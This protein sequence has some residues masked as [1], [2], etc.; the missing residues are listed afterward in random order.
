MGLKKHSIFSSKHNDFSIY[1]IITL[2]L[3]VLYII[4]LGKF[5]YDSFVELDSIYS[6]IKSKR[7]DE[8]Q[9]IAEIVRLKKLM[10]EKIDMIDLETDSSIQK[11]VTS[12]K[13]FNNIWYIPK[14]LVSISSNSVYDSKW[15]RQLLRKIAN[16]NLQKMAAQFKKEYNKKMV[17]V[18]AYRSYVYQQWIKNRW[19]PDNLCAKA[20]YSEHQSGLAVDLWEASTNYAWKN[21]KRLKWYYKWLNEN[22]YKYGFHNTYQKWLKIDWYEI[23]PWHWRYLWVKLATKLRDDNMT[24]AEFYKEKKE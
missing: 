20:G 18:S 24:I 21:N 5:L 8:N 11:F 19:C 23:E 13:S 10:Q 15:W 22:A 16:K 14:N 9:R 4:W 3:L 2:V 7:L 1:G 12:S 6:E 17:V